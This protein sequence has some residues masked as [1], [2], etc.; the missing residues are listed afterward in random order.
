MAAY[1]AIRHEATGYT[2]NM[3]VFGR[4]VRAPVDIVYASPDE[5]PA[6]TYH[7]YVEDMR[8]RMTTAFS[9][10]RSALRKAA[11]GNKRYYDIRVRP[12]TFSVGDWCIIITPENTLEDRTN[13]SESTLDRTW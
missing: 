10:V 9:E 6:K 12:N 8:D 2:P 5:A 13:G 4:E 11:E 3:L 1:R 7:G